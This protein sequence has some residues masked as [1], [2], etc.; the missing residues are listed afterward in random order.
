MH[1][2]YEKTKNGYVYPLTKTTI[3]EPEGAITNIEEAYDEFGNLLFYN[4][5]TTDKGVEVCKFYKDF[6]SP[7]LLRL[8]TSF[9][10]SAPCY[11]TSYK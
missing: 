10:C 7:I 5:V 1:T 6:K 9:S 11:L 2:T 8:V 3:Y 4:H